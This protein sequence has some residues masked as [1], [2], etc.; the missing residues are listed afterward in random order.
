MDPNSGAGRN[1]ARQMMNPGTSTYVR[2]DEAAQLKKDRPFPPKAR[3]LALIFMAITVV[4]TSLPLVLEA[5]GVAVRIGPWLSLLITLPCT[6]LAMGFLGFL[7]D[8]MTANLISGAA[9]LF[10]FTMGY[11]LEFEP[12]DEQRALLFRAV[13]PTVGAVVLA[14]FW[15]SLKTSLRDIHY[16]VAEGQSLQDI[17][18]RYQQANV[19][20]KAG[21]KPAMTPD[22]QVVDANELMAKPGYR[23]AKGSSEE[24][25]QTKKKRKKPKVR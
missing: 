10:A 8:G 22:G 23:P 9:L 7:R 20:R 24:A 13:A 15:L 3:R 16:M 6:L 19:I 14:W 5:S 1:L 18:L 11:A 21:G 12:G 17:M 2:E 25:T 4:L